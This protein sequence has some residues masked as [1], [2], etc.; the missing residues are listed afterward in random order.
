MI[1]SPADPVPVLADWLRNARAAAIFSGA[2]M[3]TESGALDGV[4]A[5]GLESGMR[6]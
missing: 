5:E 2:G 4:S 6:P 3:S 1:E